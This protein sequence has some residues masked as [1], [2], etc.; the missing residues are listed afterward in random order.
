LYVGNPALD[1]EYQNRFNI[2]YRS[3]DPEN[4]K[5]FFV[6]VFGSASQNYI[7]NSVYTNGAPEE[8][9]AG[10][11]LQ[12][13]AR[14]SRPVNLDGYWNV[15]SFM[16][17]GR[18]LNFINSNFNIRGG[19]GYSRIPGMIDE[20]INYSNRLNVG[21]GF[22]LSS[23]ISEKVD[24]NISTN[25]SYNIVENTLSTSQDN[26]FFSQSTNLRFNWT[27]WKDVVYRTELNHQYNP[28]LSAGVD[29]SYLLWN[30]SIGKKV[31][32]NQLGEVSLSVNDLLKQNVSVQRNVQADYIEDVQ[33]TV[34]QRFFMVTFSYNLRHF[35]D[36][37]E[38]PAAPSEMRREWG[39]R[40][41]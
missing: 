7:T 8:Y 12:P 21:G 3:F 35:F 9:T 16:N 11:E 38:A 15:R 1:Q 29:A 28:G 36:G 34:L 19:V 37:G 39:G 33:S 27:F 14:L 4:Y 18:P 23:N 26:N 6:G 25:S 30:M 2:R 13:G 31:F 32:K 17:Y 20:Q 41:H 24:F 22:N 5:V 10:Y 40:G